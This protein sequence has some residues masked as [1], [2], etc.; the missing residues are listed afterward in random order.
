MDTRAGR[1]RTGRF[2]F[3]AVVLKYPDSFSPKRFLQA[4]ARLGK[5][6]TK[7]PGK[8]Q[9]LHDPASIDFRWSEPPGDRQPIDEC[10]VLGRGTRLRFVTDW[11]A[12][13]LASLSD[14]PLPTTRTRCGISGD[15]KVACRS[16]HRTANYGLLVWR[17]D[18]KIRSQCMSLVYWQ[19]DLSAAA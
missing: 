3:E 7:K 4:R 5:K 12:K 6:P 18:G 13:K 9:D 17:S 10:R 15:A 14:Q 2:T 8:G 19:P 11:S 16:I 1:G